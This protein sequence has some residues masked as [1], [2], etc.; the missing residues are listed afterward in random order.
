VENA[1]EWLAAG[2]LACLRALAVS[3]DEIA[4]PT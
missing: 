1:A 4:A 2:V 3:P